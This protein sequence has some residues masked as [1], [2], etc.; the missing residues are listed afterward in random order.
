MRYNLAIIIAGFIALGVQTFLI[1][2]ML[3]EITE[4]ITRTHP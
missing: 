4:L 1:A 2:R 3:V